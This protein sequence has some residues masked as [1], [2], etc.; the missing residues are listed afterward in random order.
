MSI[1]IMVVDEHKIVREGLAT[2]IAKQPN[3]EIV[4]EATDGREALDLVEKN[5]PDLILM[6][7]TMPNLNGIEA[8]R[9]IKLK[10][11]EIEII[12]LSLHSERQFVLGM[13]RAGASGYLIKQ[14]TFDE[15][16]LAINTVMEG[17][18]YLSRE[19]ANVLVEEYI[20]KESE[21][22][23]IIDSKLTSRE[24]EVLQ[25]LAE[26]ETTKEIANNLSISLKTV[27]AH[28]RHTKSKLKAKTEA[29][30]TKIAIREGLTSL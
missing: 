29:E 4:G 15:L 18:N 23:A 6:D 27:E 26:G 17:K 14:C 21:E 11:P 8:T 9:R 5:T 1:K 28:I 2:L 3:M 10:N 7:V 24:I 30:L 13:I 22:K 19:I 25:L 16:V 20:R 12:A